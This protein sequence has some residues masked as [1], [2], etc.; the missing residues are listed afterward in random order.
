MFQLI[1]LATPAAKHTGSPVPLRPSHLVTPA[2]LSLERAEEWKE[3]INRA[4]LEKTLRLLCG[5][6]L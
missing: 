2:T 5:L 3:Q 4:L 6:M 1:T